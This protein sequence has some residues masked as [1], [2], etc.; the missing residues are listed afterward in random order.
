MKTKLFLIALITCTISA[1]AQIHVWTKGIIGSVNTDVYGQ[2]TYVEPSGNAVYTFGEYSNYSSTNSI[3]I[4]PGGANQE[5][6]TIATI[7]LANYLVKMTT[8]G[9]LIWAHSF[10]STL[11]IQLNSISADAAGCCYINGNFNG[12]FDA[13]PG[14]SIHQMTSNVGMANFLLKLDAD[15][16]F[17]WAQQFD[18][19]SIIDIAIRSNAVFCVGYF[20]ETV[21]FD[22]GPGNSSL[23]ATDNQDCFVMRLNTDGEYQ[24]VKQFGST[25]NTPDDIEYA[26][27]INVTPDGMINVSGIFSESGDFNPELGITTLT[28]V[29]GTDVFL[30]RLSA[31]GDFQWVVS[32]GT[33]IKEYTPRM[34][35]SASGT[36]YLSATTIQPNN[37]APLEDIFIARFS[38]N[39]SLLWSKLIG[40]ENSDQAI[41][42][43]V[44]EEDNLYLMGDFGSANFNVDPGA[45]GTSLHCVDLEFMNGYFLKFTPEGDLSWATSLTG[46]LNS[47]WKSSYH[48]GF[49]YTTGY[50][51]GDLD[52]APGTPVYQLNG[53][54]ERLSSYLS[55]LDVSHTLGNPDLETQLDLPFKLYPNPAQ[56]ITYAELQPGSVVTVYDLAG[57]VLMQQTV[58][59][60][61]TALNTEKLVSGTYLVEV[62]QNGQKLVQKLV[63]D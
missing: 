47:I 56:S 3:T 45:G 59:Q 42:V 61:I 48:S 15:G 14:N 31:M 54:G 25:N 23:T 46:S 7:P 17:V 6:S 37:N 39:G 18:R 8:D 9:Q 10:N 44:D 50:F 30:M 55:K 21:D 53:N 26:T 63:K 49:L 36:I 32:T 41:S 60:E 11:F 13:D 34:T 33:S 57:A 20:S 62:Q 22:N 24:W 5:L 58:Q 4:D 52:M 28:A 16:N 40:G 27:E 12:S 35:T 29:G 19:A 38:P 2:R 51:R 1:N 43:N